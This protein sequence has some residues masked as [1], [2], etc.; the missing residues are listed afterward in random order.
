[1]SKH[2]LTQYV[3][4]ENCRKLAKEIKPGFDMFEFCDNI[5]RELVK[6]TMNRTNN[7]CNKAAKLLGVRR[8]TLVEKRKRLGLPVANKN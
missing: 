4:L 7:I 6:E 2:Q 8:C 3:I 5:E 1:M